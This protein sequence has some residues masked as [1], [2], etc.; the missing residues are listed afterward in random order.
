MRHRAS[1][2]FWGYYRQLPEPIRRLADENFKLLNENP[3]HPSLRFKNVGRFWSV[4]VGA[5]YRA[6]AV[7]EGSDTIW[8]WIGHHAEYDQ[9]IGNRGR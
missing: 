7:Q 4:R 5:H 8:F 3:R 2:K 6:L 1:T 9:L